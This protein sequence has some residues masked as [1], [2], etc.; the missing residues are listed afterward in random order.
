MTDPLAPGGAEWS[1]IITPS[2]IAAIVTDDDGRSFSRYESAY[3]LWHRMKGLIDPEPPKDIF[4]VGHAFEPALAYLWCEANPGWQL[5]PGEVRVQRDDL[6]F[7]CLAT[8]DRRARSGKA[9]RIVEFKTARKLEEWGDDFTDE[10]P[11]DYV[12][13]VQAQM[14]ITGFTQR[15]AHLM[16]MGPYFK[17]HVY[18]IEYNPGLCAVIFDRCRQFWDSLESFTVPDLDDSKYTYECVREMHPDI[19]GTEVEL[20]PELSREYLQIDAEYK[21]LEKRHR[22]VKTRVLDRMGNAQTALCNGEKVATR[23]PHSR[24]GVAL[25]PNSKTDPTTLGVAA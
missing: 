4:T 19:D 3:R 9:R 1:K 13:Q 5:S 25:K 2:K 12:I 15:P 17:H 16:V 22:G 21:A 10:A 20:T 14:H 7:P 23:S 6:G 18:E 11:F 24:G 8:I